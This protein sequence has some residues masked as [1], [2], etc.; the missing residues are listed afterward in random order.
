M[1]K[2]L[3]AQQAPEAAPMEL[4]G[5]DARMTALQKHIT[6]L[7]QL[8]KVLTDAGLDEAALEKQ[9]SELEGKRTPLR[10]L[11]PPATACRASQQKL[12]E[13]RGQ[14]GRRAEE[15][16]NLEEKWGQL[17]SDTAGKKATIAANAC[18]V[19]ESKSTL[20]LRQGES[21]P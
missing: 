2:Q 6:G 12:E 13:T 5:E 7:E 1:E 15:L 9:K 20:T 17:E 4:D 14:L 3:G 10:A 19:D 8:I 11:R 18:E 21:A 16:N